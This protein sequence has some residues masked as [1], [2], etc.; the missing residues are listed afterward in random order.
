MK[1]K[2]YFK[3]GVCVP[4]S[5]SLCKKKYCYLTTAYTEKQN[6]ALLDS[7]QTPSHMT[8]NVPNQNTTGY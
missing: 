3:V 7:A 8:R 6:F 4:F 5:M 2:W 1:M